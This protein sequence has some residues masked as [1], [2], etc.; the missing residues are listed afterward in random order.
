MVENDLY[1]TASEHIHPHTATSHV[2]MQHLDH[3]CAC[4]KLPGQNAGRH[5]VEVSLP[6]LCS[7]YLSIPCCMRLNG[8]RNGNLVVHSHLQPI[9]P[10]SLIRVCSVRH[11]GVQG[12]RHELLSMASGG[13]QG[14]IK[15]EGGGAAH[16]H[17]LV[18]L[19]A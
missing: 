16:R 3:M 8:L 6:Q 9:P 1:R 5:A 17:T 19:P 14:A 15:W 10:L 13:R 4:I 2:L 12:M 11:A 18:R 7:S